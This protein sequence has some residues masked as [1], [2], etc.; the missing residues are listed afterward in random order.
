LRADVGVRYESDAYVQTSQNSTTTPVNGDT[1]NALSIVNQ[2]VW[3][4]PGSYRHFN[5]T[6]NDWA[7]SVGLNYTLSDQTSVYALGSRAYKMPALDEFLNASAQQQVSLFKSKRNITGE[8]G[9]KHAGRSFGVTVDAFYTLLKDIVSQGLVTDTISGLPIWIIQTS[10][11][12]RS[13]GLE[14]EGSGRLP[15]SGF[16]VETNWTLLRAEYATCPSTGGCP[17]GADIGTLLSGVPP[18]VGNLAVT[19]GGRSGFSGDADLHFVDR[20]CT[21]AIGC[22]N[23]L[24]TYTY[25]NLGAQYTIPAN[26]ITLRADAFNI[27]QSEGLEE[28]NPR[29]SLVGGRT[30]SLFLARPILPRAL[31]VSVGYTF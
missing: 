15:N 3:G 10:P 24:P 5:E 21:S 12:V 18:I 26:G 23:K 8:L 31:Q 6:I 14:I 9:V 7:G 19:Y 28:G 11:E 25:I 17:T 13:Y 2:D 4:A 22:T 27:T 30:S 29:L 1:L 16:G 20:R